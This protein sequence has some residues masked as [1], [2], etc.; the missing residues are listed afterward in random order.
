M[1]VFGEHTVYFMSLLDLPVYIFIYYKPYYCILIP[2]YLSTITALLPY[3]LFPPFSTLVTM[4]L[5]LTMLEAFPILNYSLI[6]GLFLPVTAA[7]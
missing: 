4:C 2:N 3:P 5:I 7:F 6:L 1:I